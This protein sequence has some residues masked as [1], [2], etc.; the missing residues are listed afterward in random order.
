VKVTGRLTYIAAYA[1][2]VALCILD[3]AGIYLRPQAST[4]GLW[5]EVNDL[6]KL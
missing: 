5:P 4:Q 6:E 1:S 2:S 3:R